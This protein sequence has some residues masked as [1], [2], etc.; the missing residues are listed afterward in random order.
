MNFAVDGKHRDFYRKQRWIEFEDLLSSN[1]LDL[2][3]QEINKILSARL[4]TP[5]TYLS[6]FPTEKLFENGRDVWRGIQS[7]KKIILSKGL[8]EAASELI[9][10]KPLRIGYDQFFPVTGQSLA[11]NSSYAV[12]LTKT[13]TLEE[14]SCIQG[15][16]CGLMLCIKSSEQS[17]N[18]NEP[19]TIFSKIA[20]NG[21]VFAPD[22]PIPF[23]ELKS[24]P[25][26]RYLLIVY[27]TSKAVYRLQENDPHV[28][29]FKQLGYNFGDKLSDTLN[30]LVYV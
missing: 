18:E 3:N 7:L 19:S 2:L 8:A 24:H 27:T 15:V 29:F 17:N 9:E 14:I 22:W 4:N 21:V 1:Q 25:D 20:G 26:S 6:A 28:Y 23:H 11:E 10:Y 13:L 16:M 12:L 5:L 30:P